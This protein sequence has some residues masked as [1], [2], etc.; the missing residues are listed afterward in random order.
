MVVIEHSYGFFAIY[1]Y[2]IDEFTYEIAHSN[3]RNTQ[4]KLEHDRAVRST[5][6]T[7]TIQTW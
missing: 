2:F 7:K 4:K 3:P 1:S 5:S 6:C